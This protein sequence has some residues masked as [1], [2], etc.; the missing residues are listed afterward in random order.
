MKIERVS[1]FVDGFNLYHA[2]DDLGQDHLKWLNLWSLMERYAA[3]PNQKLTAVYYFSAFARWLPD[4]YRRH[5]EYVRALQASRVTP[6][7]GFF[8]DKDRQCKRCGAEWIAHEEKET[9]VSIG[10]YMVN[11]AHKDTFDHA[12]LVSND[13]DLSSV[14]RMLRREFPEKRLRLITPPK[15]RASKQLV[16]EAGGAGYVRTM[17][18][19]H[20]RKH[21][22]PERVTDASGTG[23]AIR[24]PKYAPP[25]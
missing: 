19:S 17:K 13:S 24:P 8:K 15:R 25:S 10:I 20:V 22:F 7:M 21:L 11:E 12:F 16:T 2:I 23:A 6:V 5:R 14:V 18:V 4:A 9:D 1:C 3:R